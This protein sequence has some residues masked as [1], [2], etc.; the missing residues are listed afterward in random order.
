MIAM[1]PIYLGAYLEQHVCKV[2][3]GE[4]EVP[5]VVELEQRGAVRVFLLQVNVVHFRL[6]GGVSALLANVHL[7]RA[8]RTL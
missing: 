6:L 5:L 1:N 8:K 7:Q 4:L 3:V 2:R